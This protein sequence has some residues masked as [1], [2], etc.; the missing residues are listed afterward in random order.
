MRTRVIIF[1]TLLIFGS[2]LALF[3]SAFAFFRA[4]ELEQAKSRL[5]L[6]SGSLSD[7]LKRFEYLP[8]ILSKD[9]LVVT[10]LKSGDAGMLNVRFQIFAERSGLEAIYLM[11]K[12]GLVIAASNH[13]QKPTFVGNNYGFRPYFKSSLAGSAGRFFG[14][15]ATTGR[16]GYFFSEPVLGETGTIEGVLAVKLD[17]SEFQ[18]SWESNGDNVLVTDENGIVVI[19]TNA[20]WLYK[21][22]KALPSEQLTQIRDSRQF[23]RHPID[24]LNWSPEGDSIAFENKRYLQVRDAKTDQGWMIR[25]LQVESRVLERAIST[26][27]VFGSALIVLVLIA[28]YLR[29]TRVQQA[30]QR[31]EAD[32]EELQQAN[33]DLEEAHRELKR[34]GQLAALGRVAASVTHELGQPLSALKNYLSAGEI[35]GEF[36]RDEMMPKIDRVI[37]RVENIA[38]ELRFFT[39]PQPEDETVFDLNDAVRAALELVRHD[40][41][42]LGCEISVDLH[43][44]ELPVSGNQLRFERVIINLVKNGVQASADGPQRELAIKTRLDGPNICCEVSD[45]GPGL[46][47]LSFDDLKEPFL[48]T[49]PSGKG[50]GLGLSIVAQIVAEHRGDLSCKNLDGKG[51]LFCVSVPKAATL[52]ASTGVH[53]MIETSHG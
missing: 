1:L 30:L 26:T 23:G 5:S 53:Q 41:S 37:V 33:L 15:G 7:T 43:A 22:I 4:D 46:G 3:F 50:M 48:T 38:K 27:M 21:S 39:Q 45:T 14:V 9:P 49:K 12:A 8:H 32:R 11:D 34:T 6:F 18:R 36:K 31:S 47:D 42:L 16:P 44:S 17:M 28:T 24:P 35:S 52:N 19:A 20:Q 29:S 25:L 2:V 10:A 40:A 13:N 51:A